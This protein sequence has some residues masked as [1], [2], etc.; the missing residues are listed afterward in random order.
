MR[1]KIHGE[2]EIY[3]SSWVGLYIADVE[4]PDGKRIDHHVV[5]VEPVAGVVVLDDQQ[6]VLMLWRHRFATDTWNWE[7]PAGIV[8]PGETP[9]QTA[10]REVEEETGYRPEALD[11]LAYIQPIGGMTNAEHYVFLA[12]SAQKIGEPTDCNEA[13]RIA[14]VPLSDMLDKID[15]REIVAGF[16]MVAIL[17]LLADPRL[18]AGQG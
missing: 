18:L 11:K 5:R 12:R 2:R 9:E 16:T 8:D 3:N 15:K 7:I 13:D 14:W 1:W 10:A 17:R 6:R 4:L